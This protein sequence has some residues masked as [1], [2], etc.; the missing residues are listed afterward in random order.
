MRKQQ[1]GCIY[2]KGDNWALRWRE[3]VRTPEGGETRR[4]RFKLLGEVTAE[5]RRNKHRGTGKLRIP[6]EIQQAADEITEAANRQPVVSVLLTIGEFV[7]DYLKD[8]KAVLRPGTYEGYAQLWQKY[9]KPRIDNKVLRDFKRPDAYVLWHEIAKA[10]TLSRQTMNHIRFFMSGVFK[11]ALNRGLMAGDNPAE[12][13]LPNGLRGRGETEVYGIEEVNRLLELFVGQRKAQAVIALDFA[14][15]LRKS[16]LS[17]LGWADYERNDSGAI[18]RVRQ[19]NV[20]GLVSQPKTESSAD[21]VHISEDVCWYIDRYRDSIGKPE[22][23]FMFGHV[24]KKPMNMDS[25]VR[26]TIMP[27]LARCATC[28]KQAGVHGKE[29]DHEY[30]RSEAVPEWKG[31]HAFRR[32]NATYLAKQSAGDGMRAASIMLRHSDEGVTAEHYVKVSR[33]QKRVLAARKVVQI[34]EQRQAAAATIGAGLKQT[35]V[36]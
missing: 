33:Q 27:V 4:L 6:T 11:A 7:K 3:T 22:T 1:S 16:E 8:K 5:H 21:D 30:Q 13:D 23:G 26:W 10:Y 2:V 25:F 35:A 36:N 31:W 20:R 9:L 24:P 32:G 15:G 18:I 14:S 34:T 12:A 19:S 17:A 28:G 29:T